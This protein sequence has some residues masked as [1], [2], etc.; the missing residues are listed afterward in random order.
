[1]MQGP[2]PGASQPRVDPQHDNLAIRLRDAEAQLR[3][4]RAQLLEA[5]QRAAPLGQLQEDLRDAQWSLVDKERLHADELFALRQQLEFSE[6][7]ANH[8]EQ[9]RA[10][11][12][13]SLSWKVTAPLRAA[14]RAVDSRSHRT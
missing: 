14:K 2:E 4:A 5:E 10:D 3:V 13:D 7:R 8:L 1:M 6:A 12:Q 9:V 11:L